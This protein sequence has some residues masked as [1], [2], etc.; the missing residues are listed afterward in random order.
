MSPYYGDIAKITIDYS[1]IITPK[2][3]YGKVDNK[4]RMRGLKNC[5]IDY[6]WW[7]YAIMEHQNKLGGGNNDLVCL[8]FKL[9]IG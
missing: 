2:A 8:G 6:F 7:S 5:R 4:G 9:T 1:Y 3:D